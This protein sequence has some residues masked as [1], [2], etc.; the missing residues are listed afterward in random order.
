MKFVKFNSREISESGSF[1]KINTRE[2][3]KNIFPREMK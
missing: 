1:A 2:N 3:K